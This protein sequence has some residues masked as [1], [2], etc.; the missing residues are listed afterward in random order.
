MLLCW[1]FS[2]GVLS[3]L[4][5]DNGVLAIDRLTIPNRFFISNGNYLCYLK[6]KNYYLFEEVVKTSLLQNR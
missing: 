5:T 1:Y 3:P 2:D 6:N 4:V